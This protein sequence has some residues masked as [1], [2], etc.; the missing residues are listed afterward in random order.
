MEKI[1][2]V[3]NK[4]GLHARPALK[5]VERI[6]KYKSEVTI[7]KEGRKANAKSVLAI[8]SLGISKGST[9]KVHVNGEDEELTAKE[10]ED[11]ILN[12]NEE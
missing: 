8:V 7:E 2:E 3:N 10:I 4:Y 6:K 11:F 1:F 5:L 12:E 9:I